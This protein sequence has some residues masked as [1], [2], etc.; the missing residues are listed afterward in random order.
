[1]AAAIDMKLIK[2][3]FAKP[4]YGCSKVSGLEGSS[5]DASCLRELTDE[6]EAAQQ[7]KSDNFA[8]TDNEN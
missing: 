7:D 8:Q 6:P 3:T 5:L 2:P 1:M 4:T